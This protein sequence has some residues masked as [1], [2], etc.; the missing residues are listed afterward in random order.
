MCRLVLICRN[1]LESFNKVLKFFNKFLNFFNKVLKYFNKVLKFF[2]NLE[3]LG[4]GKKCA[5]SSELLGISYQGLK[6]CLEEQFTEGMTW[7]NRSDWHV[8]HIVPC[9]AFDL[10]VSAHLLLVQE[11]TTSVGS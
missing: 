3:I 1:E 6:E 11:P 2:K 8:D 4:L 7:E 9:T 10:L 5:S